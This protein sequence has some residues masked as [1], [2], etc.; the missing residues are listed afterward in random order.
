MYID[1]G[2]PPTWVLGVGLTSMLRDLTEGRDPFA[3]L[4]VEWG[5]VLNWALETREWSVKVWTVVHRSFSV[6]R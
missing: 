3:G 4:D 1:K 5:R 2:E 6:L